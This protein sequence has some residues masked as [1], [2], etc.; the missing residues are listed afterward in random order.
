[1]LSPVTLAPSRPQYGVAAN[2]LWLEALMQLPKL[3]K[4]PKRP[5]AE[6]VLTTLTGREDERGWVSEGEAPLEG[7]GQRAMKDPM[8]L[9]TLYAVGPR[10]RSR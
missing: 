5:E 4:L 6:V 9:Q 3:P 7:L 10:R 1:V 2:S 8:G